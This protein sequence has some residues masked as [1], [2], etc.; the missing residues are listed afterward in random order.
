VTPVRPGLVLHGWPGTDH[1][2]LRAPPTADGGVPAGGLDLLRTL[3]HL[4]YVDQPGHGPR[5][6][7]HT[8]GPAT[9][10]GYAR[11]AALEAAALHPDP[12][13]VLGHFHGAGV[14]QE[15]A[16]RH[17]DRVEA[18]VLIAATP[19]E[20]GS[21]ED[22]ADTFAANIRPPE[23]EILQRVPPESDPELAATM[24]ALESFFFADRAHAPTVSV[25][26]DT[27]FSS[28]ASV[29]WTQALNSWSTVD[30]LAQVA[31]PTLLVTGRHD[32]FAPPEEAQRIARRIPGS[33]LVVLEGSGHLPWIE[34]PGPFVATVTDWLAANP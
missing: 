28:S 11:N 13:V 8:D 21:T 5:G 15:L 30:R 1:T 3:L 27:E 14:A 12:V 26:D 10:E 2:Y 33:E 20:L 29:A 22:L 18:L 32:V 9:M 31:A 24:G 16:V 23:A 19:G 6:T 7:S 25:F 17:P 34:E 4:H